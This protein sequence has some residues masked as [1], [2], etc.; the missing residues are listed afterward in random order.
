[1]AISTY[2]GLQ[3]AVADWLERSDLTSRIPDFISLAEAKINRK[4]RVR[5]MQARTT[6][7]VDAEYESLPADFRQAESL[8]FSDAGVTFE[9]RTM[10]AEALAERSVGVASPARPEFYA[11]IGSQLR[12]WPTPDKAYSAE[13]TY[14]QKVPALSDAAPS[15]WALANYPDVYLYGA[16]AEAG[17]Y[18]R[19]T[20][21]L[22]IWS[23]AF[24][25]ALAGVKADQ[26][27]EPG[28]L[29]SDLS[30]FGRGHHYNIMSDR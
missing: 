12:V 27:I 25:K 14:Y 21:A 9:C 8:I 20:E 24:E 28:K 29:R 2:A 22:A 10:P 15:N 30:H 4:L 5:L 17:P 18:L 19:D 16:L 7:T 11:L 13:L 1:M 23:A 6:L 26:K 3:T